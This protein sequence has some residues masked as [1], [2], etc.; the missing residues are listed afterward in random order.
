VGTRHE[1]ETIPE[2]DLGDRESTARL[3]KSNGANSE[4]TGPQHGLV[5]TN[6]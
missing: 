5:A 1:V 3:K 2:R 6:Y 4:A